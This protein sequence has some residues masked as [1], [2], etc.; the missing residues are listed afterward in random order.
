MKNLGTNYTP[1]L[2]QISF[3]DIPLDV[4]NEMLY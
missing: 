1:N 3:N 2:N 4:I